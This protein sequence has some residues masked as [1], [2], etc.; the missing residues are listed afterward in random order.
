MRERSAL[1]L[2]NIARHEDIY[3]HHGS[4]HQIAAFS[5]IG[6]AWPPPENNE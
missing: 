6:E 4:I 3:N 5:V 1:A 2:S